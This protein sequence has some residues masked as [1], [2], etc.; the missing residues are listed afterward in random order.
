M[1]AVTLLRWLT[2]S[3]VSVIVL[4]PA[5]LRAA[6]WPPLPQANGT[7]SIPVR[8]EPDGA[9]RPL[10]IHLRYPASPGG[11]PGLANVTA[12]TGLTLVL[13]NWGGR[14][15]E[16]ASNPDVLA[17]TYDVVAIGVTYY[18]SGDQGKGIEPEPYDFGYRQALD[19]LRAL[20]YV[21]HGLRATGHEFADR[22]IYGC[23]GSGG[24]NVIQMANKFAPRTFACIVDLSGMASLTDDMA[25]NLPGGAALNARYSRDPASPA[26]LTPGGQQIRDLGNPAH[27]AIQKQAGCTCKVVMIHGADDAPCP[28]EDKR[29]VAEAMR[30]AGLDAVP[31]ILTKDDVDGTI[32]KNCGHSIGDRTALLQAFAGECIKPDS[33]AHC[34]LPGP[35]D[36]ERGEDITYPTSDGAYT[37]SFGPAGPAIS[38]DKRSS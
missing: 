15:F 37:I 12:T 23:G 25:Y 27:L 1:S 34:E 30:A 21:Y 14:V 19:A 26:F 31:H 6:D 28:A 24:G 8:D 35:C 4:L 32:V 3:L 16:G 9:E 18:Q 10:A 2:A 29:R 20:H 38:F 13:H 7:V 5:L 17:T 22:R 36:F 33:P 11:K